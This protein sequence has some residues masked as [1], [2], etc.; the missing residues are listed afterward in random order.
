MTSNQN[1]AVT[2]ER[3]IAQVE[4]AVLTNTYICISMQT[5]W[6][7]E[8]YRGLLDCP[9]NP[10]LLSCFKFNMQYLS[11]PGHADAKWVF[12]LLKISNLKSSY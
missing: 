5:Q 7:T 3:D 4:S 9:K 11:I 8:G 1:E 2:C 12:P 6:M 10:N